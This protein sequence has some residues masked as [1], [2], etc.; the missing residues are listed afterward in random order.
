MTFSASAEVQP[1]RSSSYLTQGSRISWQGL[2]TCNVSQFIP[3]T[4]TWPERTEPLLTCT[5]GQEPIQL[6]TGVYAKLFRYIYQGQTG[7]VELDWD[8]FL[9][10]NRLKDREGKIRLSS[11]FPTDFGKS[12]ALA[13]LTQCRR[14]VYETHQNGKCWVLQQELRKRD[15]YPPARK[16]TDES[17]LLSTFEELQKL[18][19]RHWS[20]GERPKLFDDGG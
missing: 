4:Q 6:L 16:S 5:Y 1:V 9:P 15:V 8:V 20:S 14:L 10:E 13:F 19:W 3:D 17:T 12:R 2:P 11:V 7:K 18:E